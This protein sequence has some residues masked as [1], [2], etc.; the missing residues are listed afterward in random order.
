LISALHGPISDVVISDNSVSAAQGQSPVGTEGDVSAVTERRTSTDT[1]TPW[2]DTGGEPTA[3]STSILASR[4]TSL[5]SNESRH[6]LLGIHVRGRPEAGFEQRLEYVVSGDASDIDSWLSV[7]GGEA[8]RFRPSSG[9]EDIL[10]I[11][12]GVPLE[13]PSW[14]RPVR[15]EDLRVAADAVPELW[16]HVNAL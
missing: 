7:W 3:R 2:P 15:F 9:G 13:L 6:G 5:V 10:V 1:G 4:D 12:T 11:R 16:E 8:A 14:L